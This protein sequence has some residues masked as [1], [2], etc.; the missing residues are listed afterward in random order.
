MWLRERVRMAC[1]RDS[2]N[3][4]NAGAGAKAHIH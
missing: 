2:G 4:V 1:R 3:D